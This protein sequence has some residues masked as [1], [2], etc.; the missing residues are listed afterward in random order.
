MSTK[1]SLTASLST[2]QLVVTNYR[3]F[4]LRKCRHPEMFRACYLVHPVVRWCYQGV[5]ADLQIQP[6]T[7]S[8]V[9]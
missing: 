8:G 3:C 5:L 9:L 6:R 4:V 7:R 1:F 2:A